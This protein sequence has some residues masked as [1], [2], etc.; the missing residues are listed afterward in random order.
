MVETILWIASS[1]TF[2]VCERARRNGPEIRN[3]AAG[4]PDHFDSRSCLAFGQEGAL[5]E[6]R[7]LPILRTLSG[8]AHIRQVHEARY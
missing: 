5:A 3:G 6:L 1:P 8:R 2:G 4:L 7:T